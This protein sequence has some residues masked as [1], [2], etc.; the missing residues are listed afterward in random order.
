MGLGF[1]RSA[2]AGAGVGGR[3]KVGLAAAGAWCRAHG[4]EA[5]GEDYRSEADASSPL[6]AG[7]PGAG[8]SALPQR[9]E[10]AGRCA[11][12]VAAGKGGAAGGLGTL[13]EIDACLPGIGSA[14]L[15]FRR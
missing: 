7:R 14:L 8:L 15:R 5:E 10:G 13:R 2:A 6:E 3:G 1:T 11:A 12:A 4:R 9:R